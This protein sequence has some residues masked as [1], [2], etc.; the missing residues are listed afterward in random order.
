MRSNRT[1]SIWIGSRI[2]HFR[3]ERA[4]SQEELA[5]ICELHRTYIGS[6]E[7]GEKNITI[8]NLYKISKALGVSLSD[9]FSGIE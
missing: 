4:L 6:C 8:N 3:L 7:R 2:R 1:L 5:G 9:F